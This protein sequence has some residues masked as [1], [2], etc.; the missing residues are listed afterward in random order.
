MGGGRTGLSVEF[1]GRVIGSYPLVYMGVAREVLGHMPLSSSP[2]EKSIFRRRCRKTRRKRNWNMSRL[3]FSADIRGTE[4]YNQW[5]SEMSDLLLN[6]EVIAINQDPL[7]QQGRLVASNDLSW[8]IYARV[9]DKGRIA[10]AVLCLSNHSVTNV[11]V[12]WKILG[13]EPNV[14]MKVRA[15]WAKADLGVHRN[16]LDVSVARH[17]TV[18]LLLVPKTSPSS[19]SDHGLVV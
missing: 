7:G 9:L 16:A 15:V 17:D 19:E 2:Q 10:V 12:T 1:W 8:D 11:S 18:L 4:V 14:P 13:L 6:P 3:I 5:T